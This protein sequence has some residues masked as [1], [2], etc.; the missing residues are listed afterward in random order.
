LPEGAGWLLVEFGG[1]TEDE[2]DA[3]AK[4]MMDALKSAKVVP[5]MKLYD[6]EREEAIVW[7][8]RE[9]GLGAT[10]N[11]PGQPLTWE[12][13]EDSA[14]HPEKLGGYLRDLR[15]LFDKYGYGCDL[16]G[17]F[18]QGCVHTRI[19]FDLET[20]PG[21]TKFRAFLDDAADL[22]VSY[23]GSLSGE[24]GDGQSKADMLPKM[25]G[26]ELIEAFREFKS[27]WD[28]DGK[29]NPGKI[30]QP[31]HPTE[32]L[33]LGVD[34]RPWSPKT[35]FQ[36]PDDDG[37]FERAAMR[38]VGVGECRR[39]DK[40]VMCPSYM[41][42]REEEHSTR[43]R[44]HLLF[45]M[46][47][48]KEIDA[49]WNNDSVKHALDLCLA[50]KGCKGECPVNVDMATYKAEFLSHYYERKLRPPHAYA[51]G[52]IERW[53]RIASMTPRMAN[54]TMRLPFVKS[55]AQISP[56]RKMPRYAHETFVSQF[57]KRDHATRKP[58]RPVMLWP[59]TFNNYFHP[60]TAM[61]A[62]EVLER[63]GY[64]VIIP[65]QHLCCGRP[66]YDFGFL[67]IAKR[68]L[69]EIM[70]VLRP[71]LERGTPIIGLEPSCVSVFRD[72]LHNLFPT[73]EDAKRL[74][75]LVVTLSEFLQRENCDLPKLDR[76]ALVQAHCHHESIMKF[77]A[78]EAV[79]KQM[80]LQV[81]R[82]DSGC[83]GM[84]GAFGFVSDNYEVSLRIGD[85]VLLPK[86]RAAS[87]ETLIIA[88]GF[89]CREQIEQTTSRRALH[90]AEVLKMAYGR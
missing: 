90:L 20:A 70:R 26:P 41:V 29:M 27:I 2:S 64:Q 89:S 61:A 36:F 78:E 74:G 60:Q 56:H 50:C 69:R 81:E 68:R 3:H 12:G 6:D 66:L 65:K 76:K 25:Y 5:S 82:P 54:L 14:V 31:Y 47:E 39:F 44:A 77:D 59:D 86:V 75:G 9:S 49:S 1:E 15:K 8:I 62:A 83:C 40:G 34:Y 52:W 79:M 13:W 35:H 80:G 23:G 63:L 30:V 10:A 73:S 16:Y 4:K 45:E 84:A 28:P 32:N 51:M 53:S 48:G 33:R 42:T 38:C 88:D 67:R 72:E 7:R 55:L 24:H 71:Q 37:R 85:R 18:G 43:G 57:R 58:G 17:H 46:F 22:V 11:V 21:I 19:D 87:H